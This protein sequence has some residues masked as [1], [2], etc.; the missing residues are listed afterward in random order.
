[1]HHGDI[2]RL[3]MVGGALIGTAGLFLNNREAVLAAATI[4]TAG[5]VL[6]THDEFCHKS[7]LRGKPIPLC[8]CPHPP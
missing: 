8:E 2:G 1:M 3:L 4:S 7:C 5:L 6:Y